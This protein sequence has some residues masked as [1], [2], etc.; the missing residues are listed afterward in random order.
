MGRDRL[1]D[2]AERGIPRY[3]LVT[4]YDV[5]LVAGLVALCAG[6]VAVASWLA[7]ARSNAE[8]L[9]PGARQEHEKE[10]AWVGWFVPVVALWFPYVF[11]RD[12]R[13]A[14]APRG[15]K[16]LLLSWWFA[17]LL[18]VST[19]QFGPFL[20]ADP[21]T[22]PDEVAQLGGI[23]TFNAVLALLAGV[24]W[25]LVVRRITSEQRAAHGG[26]LPDAARARSRTP[27][28]PPVPQGRPPS[29]PGWSTH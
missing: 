25:V 2:A 5:V 8:V 18:Y 13:R 23:E 9:N 26:G 20:R 7:R 4:A 17:F 3:Q 16:P 6:W 15:V 21:S 29:H 10:W 28:P 24:L 14:T 19:I 27:W 12:V 11:V 1:V 22:G